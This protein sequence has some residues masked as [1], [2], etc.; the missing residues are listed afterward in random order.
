[1]IGYHQL[2]ASL[3]RRHELTRKEVVCRLRADRGAACQG[4]EPLAVGD[5]EVLCLEGSPLE[6]RRNRL[7]QTLGGPRPD[8]QE[9]KKEKQRRGPL[10]R[11]RRCCQYAGELARRCVQSRHLADERLQCPHVCLRESIDEGIVPKRGFL[12]REHHV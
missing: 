10:E 2:D 9:Q 7:G 6:M 3:R 8:E 1:V 5:V 4:F 12:L 11:P